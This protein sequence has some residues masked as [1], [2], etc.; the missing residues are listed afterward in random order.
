MAD[1]ELSYMISTGL[2]DDFVVSPE[3]A[4]MIKAAIWMIL[5]ENI[6]EVTPVKHFSN[7][8]HSCYMNDLRLGPARELVSQIL[9]SDVGI[10]M[11]IVDYVD[12]C[13][14]DRVA[15]AL[16]D[17]Y[18]SNEQTERLFRKHDE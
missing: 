14:E 8:E 3:V 11:L 7:G 15:K 1:V 13:N 5:T 17:T 6:E 16:S 4:G 12:S 9:E 18:L 2:K 10:S